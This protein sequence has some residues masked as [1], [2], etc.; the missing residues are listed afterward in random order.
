MKNFKATSWLAVLI[1]ALLLVSTSP[2]FGGDNKSQS[3]EKNQKSEKSQNNENSEGSELSSTYD[4]KYWG[5]PK[6]DISNDNDQQEYDRAQSA[7]PGIEVAGTEVFATFPGR[8][9]VTLAPAGNGNLIDHGGAVLNEVHIYPIFWGPATTGFDTN[10]KNAIINFFTAIQCG[11]GTPTLSCSGHSGAVKEYFRTKS[12]VSPIIKFSGSFTDTTKPPTSSPS[13][14]SIVAEAAKVVKASNAAIDPLGLYLVF[15]NNYPARVNFCAWHSAG[16]Y[17]AT[18]KSVATWFTVAYMPY[19]GTTAGC[20]SRNIPGWASWK[21][22]QPVDSVIN[23]T[24]HELYE[25]MTD[26]LLNNRYAW[27]DSAGYENGD[28]CA[29]SY[30]STIN[31]YRVQSEYLNSTQSCPDLIN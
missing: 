2:S 27:Y 9:A 1:S 28:K 11:A 4:S 15:T 26:S 6:K 7:I 13:T 5:T 21:T 31:G 22:S 23:V 24:T 8:N 14:A 29:W 10:Y 3:S 12:N 25:V 18:T 17:K 30:G 19:V 16:S 20:S